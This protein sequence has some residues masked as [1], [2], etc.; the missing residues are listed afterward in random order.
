MVLCLL[1]LILSWI[2]LASPTYNITI[3]QI[4][5]GGNVADLEFHAI[6]DS[7]TSFTYLNDPAYTLIADKVSNLCHS[8][9]KWDHEF[10]CHTSC[11]K[12]LFCLQF[13]SLIK[14]DRPSSHSTDSDLPFEHC[15]AVR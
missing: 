14:A 6:F 2:L 11:K 13:N 10:S 4:K 15:Y 1:I 7:G 3:T 8:F 9:L 5:V 12:F